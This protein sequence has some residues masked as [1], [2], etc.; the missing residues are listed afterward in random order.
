MECKTCTES[1]L[2]DDCPLNNLPFRDNKVKYI[3]TKDEYEKYISYLKTKKFAQ[4]KFN[5]DLRHYRA[6]F[7][8]NFHK[9]DDVLPYAQKAMCEYFPD[10]IGK[11][12]GRKIE[13]KQI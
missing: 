3:P 6:F 1:H 13:W 5:A 10:Y 7:S 4:K 11:I 2:L 12:I 8:K 9:I